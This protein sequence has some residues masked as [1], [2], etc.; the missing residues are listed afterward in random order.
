MGIKMDINKFYS[1]KQ[2]CKSIKMITCYD[3]WSAKIIAQ[4]NI[5]CVL[6]GDSA[7]MVMHGEKDTITANIDMMTNHIKAVA[8]GIGNKFI[9]GDMPFLSYAKS[10]SETMQVVEKIMQSGA[11]AIKL[12]GVNGYES[13]IKH[14]VNSGVPVMGHIGFTPQSANMFGNKIVRGRGDQAKALIADAKKL[15]DLGCFSIVLECVPPNIARDVTNILDIPTIGIG[16]GSHT[17][18]Q[19]LVL[20]DMLGA[21]Q[22]F[23]PKFLKQ[24]LNITDLI[25]NAVNE[26][27][28]EVDQGIFPTQEHCYKE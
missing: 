20:Q 16:A 3:Y 14:I 25:K 18:G 27:C 21:N 1:M 6:V 9:I 28:F 4:T 19:V 11:N 24:Y 2:E 23:K 17:S 5:D 12:E 10:I 15:Q 22:E 8:N 26:Y 13:I 7:A